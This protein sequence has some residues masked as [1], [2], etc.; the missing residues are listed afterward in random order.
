M[1]GPL[2]TIRRCVANSRARR[3]HLTYYVFDLLYLDGEDL[4]PLSERKSKLKALVAK[5]PHGF[6][7]ADHGGGRSGDVYAQACKMGREGIVS[8]R[9]DTPYRSGRQEGWIK[10]K[11]TTLTFGTDAAVAA[12]STA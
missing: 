3:R 12:G 7:Y 5:V 1:Q 8:K 9:R 2:P 11:C 10:T 4:R 6:L